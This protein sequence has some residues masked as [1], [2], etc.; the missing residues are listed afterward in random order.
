MALA[1]SHY[2][3]MKK[4]QLENVYDSKKILLISV[5]VV[6]LTFMSML[7]YNFLIIRYIIVVIF[8]GIALVALKR[9]IKYIKEDK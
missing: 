8:F 5:I 1:I 6:V 7:I 3:F 2:I 4:I 9:V